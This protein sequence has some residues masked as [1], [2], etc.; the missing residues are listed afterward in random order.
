[1]LALVSTAAD[2]PNATVGAR[3]G[4]G[5][6]ALHTQ[7]SDELVRGLRWSGPGA[8]LALSFE[9]LGPRA[10]QEVELALGLAYLENRYEHAGAN[11]SLGAEWRWLH[12][13]GAARPSGAL[14]VGAFIRLA[15]EEQVY[16][17]WD[18]E[19]LYWL[20][21]YEAGPAVAWEL[22]PLRGHHLAASA[23]LP[24]LAL[25]TRPPETRYVKVDP[26][27]NPTTYLSMPHARLRPA[28]FPRWI[29]PALR[30]SWLSP[31]RGAWRMRATWTAT[32]RAYDLPREVR[33]LS[34]A[35][36]VIAVRE[37]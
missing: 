34:H 16:V 23:T 2:G 14:R 8:A 36:A 13:A 19:H 17:D 26:F 6:S 30:A 22:P 10:S 32:Y 35:L 27:E 25:A 24:L 5:L 9:R 11:L 37:L 31:A 12:R 1:M 4:A 7:V 29:A 20:G 15:L 18:E 33:Q 21:A 28:A 3:I